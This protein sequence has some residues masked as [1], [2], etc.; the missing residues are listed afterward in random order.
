MVPA[1]DEIT[2]VEE[3]IWNQEKPLSLSLLV[4]GMRLAHTADEC[5]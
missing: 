1:G 4:D 3:G 2:P 5:S